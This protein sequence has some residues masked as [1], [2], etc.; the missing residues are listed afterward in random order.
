[1]R[2]VLVLLLVLASAGAFFLALN[3]GSDEG[4]QSPIQNENPGAAPQVE[5][6]TM[7]NLGGSPSSRTQAEQ[8][9]PKPTR[10]LHPSANTGNALRGRVVLQD[11]TAIPD[12][13]VVLTRYGPTDFLAPLGGDRI[14]D[15]TETTNTEG[16]FAF[17]DVVAG[18][19][20]TVVA[21]HPDHG[22]RTEPFL[23]VAEGEL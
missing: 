4:A 14:P 7:T 22:R 10:E 2:P 19:D 17:V 6:V 20:Y 11:G 12:A 1:M 23:S 15:R 5:P 8:A 18:V 3:L 9:E 16:D 21:S 13:T